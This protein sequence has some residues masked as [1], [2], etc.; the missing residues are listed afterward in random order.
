M[1]LHFRDIVSAQGTV[2]KMSLFSF[3]MASSSLP[4][5]DLPKQG[6]WSV[7]MRMGVRSA[8]LYWSETPVYFIRIYRFR[9]KYSNEPLKSQKIPCF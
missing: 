5:S 2:W 4:K 7:S 3:G 8:V 9:I 6:P 1:K